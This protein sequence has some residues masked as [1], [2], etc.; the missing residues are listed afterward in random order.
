MKIIFKRK[1]KKGDALE[2]APNNLW[3]VLWLIIFKNNNSK[4]YFYSFLSFQ[5]I[6]VV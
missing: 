4:A 1:N 2:R 5:T 6:F 3:Q